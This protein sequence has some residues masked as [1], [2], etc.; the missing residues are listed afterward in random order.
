MCKTINMN[1]GLPV[2]HSTKPFT[3]LYTDLNLIGYISKRGRSRMCVI[4]TSD[5]SIFYN[6]M[7]SLHMN[8]FIQ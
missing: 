3:N 2:N 7:T 1:I 8:V 5:G 6:N 4:G